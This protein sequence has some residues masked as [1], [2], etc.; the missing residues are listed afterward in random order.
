M[1]GATRIEPDP[2]MSTVLTAELS[3]HYPGFGPRVRYPRLG[4]NLTCRF[5]LPP[6]QLAYQ[7]RPL[8][9]VNHSVNQVY[10]LR[11]SSI[12]A[13]S[14]RR[15]IWLLLPKFIW[16]SRHGWSPTTRSPPSKAEMITRHAAIIEAAFPACGGRDRG[17]RLCLIPVG[18]FRTVLALSLYG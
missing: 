4:L 13:L 3:A 16:P 1:V 17:D 18:A 12:H 6:T 8:P 7:V 15:P 9:S 10:G 2:A 5:D 14:L 11:T